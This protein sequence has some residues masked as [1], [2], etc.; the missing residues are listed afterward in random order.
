MFHRAKRDT[1]Q[2]NF[3]KYTKSV[4]DAEKKRRKKH[5]KQWWVIVAVC[6]S[7]FNVQQIWKT[8]IYRIPFLSF[9]SLYWISLTTVLLIHPVVCYPFPYWML[10]RSLLIKQNEFAVFFISLS[11]FP[12]PCWTAATAFQETASLIV[13]E[14]YIAIYTEKIKTNS[15]IVDLSIHL[16]G[17]C[18]FIWCFVFLRV[19]APDRLNA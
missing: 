2:I 8:L 11:R 7:S 14:K 4:T 5:N 1:R 18:R 10:M 19:R 16:F 9:N 12:C 13:L 17:L 15:K 3:I 6:M